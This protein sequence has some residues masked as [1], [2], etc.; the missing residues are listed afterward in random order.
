MKKRQTTNHILMVRPAHFAF[1]EE[2]AA[3][4]AFQEIDGKDRTGEISTAALAEF[5]RMV[6]QLRDQGVD[7]IVQQ[8]HPSVFRPDAVFPNN[9]VSFHQ[10]G[11]VIT[12]PMLSEARRK[13][14]VESYIDALRERFLIS[15]RVHFEPF[16]EQGLILEGTGS[17]I[18]DRIHRIAYACLS[19]RTDSRMLGLFCQKAGYKK[20]EFQALDKTGLPIYHT[21]VMMALGENFAVICL[22]SIQNEKERK[23]V[24]RA[25]RKSKKAIVEISLDQ[26]A[27]F[28]GNMLQVR[29][30]NGLPLLVMSSRAFQSLSKA[31]LIQLIKRTDV[32]HCPI[33]TIEKYGGGSVRCMMAEVFLPEK[34]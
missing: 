33:E 29:K 11:K 16:E 4:N 6:E 13:E 7:I 26:M 18:L 2:T 30:A 32:V 31:H 21:N 23:G 5:D 12:Y 1:N 8:D 20:V 3:S 27:A 24:L 14:R 25:L 19:P 34:T 10:D 17:L 15:E 9:W 28:A 22:E